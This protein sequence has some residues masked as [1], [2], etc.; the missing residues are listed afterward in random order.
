M[1]VFAAVVVYWI[2]GSNE[3]VCRFVVHF[4]HWHVVVVTK[5]LCYV[6]IRSGGVANF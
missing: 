3:L 6:R 5:L 2:L 4:Q 1:S